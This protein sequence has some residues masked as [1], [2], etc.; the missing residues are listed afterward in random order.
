[1]LQAPTIISPITDWSPGQNQTY[2][3]SDLIQQIKGTIPV[4]SGLG[5]TKI[6]TVGYR[7]KITRNGVDTSWTSY[8][9][10]GIVAGDTDPDATEVSWSFNTDGY[11][12]LAEGDK[13]TLNFKSLEYV[14]RVSEIGSQTDESSPV[15]LIV[16]VISI[17]D[18]NASV[19]IPTG[20]E[21]EKSR[22]WI[23]LLVPSSSFSLNSNSTFLGCNFY[24][25]LDAGGGSNGYQLINDSYINDPDTSETTTEQVSQSVVESESEGVTITTTRS[26]DETTEYYTYTITKTVLKSLITQG[27][28]DNVFLSDNQTLDEDAV[29]YFVMTA[30]GYDSTLNQVVE[31]YYSLELKGEFVRYSTDFTGLPARRRSDV[32][33]SIAKRATEN[34]NQVNIVSGQVIR[35][36]MDAVSDEFARQYV[37]QDFSF[38]SESIDSLL[39]YDDADQDGES[40]DPLTSINKK[41]L[42]DAL[43]ISDPVIVQTLIDNQFDKQ[44]ANFNLSRRAAQRATG[45][46]LF[47]TSVEPTADILIP[48]GTQVTTSGDPDLNIN[49][50][51]FRVIGQ[52]ILEADNASSYYNATRKRYEISATIEAVSTG[53]S[54]NV[55]ANTITSAT[56]LDPNL[57]V[58]NPVPT[59]H[60]D[61]EES[62]SRLGARIKLARA[63]FDSGTKPGYLSTAYGVANVLEAKVVEAGNSLMVRDYDQSENRHIGGK[64]DIYIK[65]STLS[66]VTDQVAFKFEYPTDV[67][68]DKTGERFYV[69]DAQEFRIKTNNPRV[70]TDTPI[71]VVNSVRNSTR[72]LNYDLT[73]IQLLGDTVILSDSSQTNVSVGMAAFDV[74]EVDYR[75]RSSNII[76][77]ENQPVLSITSVV[78]SNNTTISGNEYQLI[79]RED[80]LANGRSTISKDGIEFLFD[81]INDVDEFITIT[82]EEHVIR[83]RTPAQLVYKGVDESSIVVKSTDD[84]TVV[85]TKDVDYTVD[86]GNQTTFTSIEIK[87]NGAIRSGDEISVSYQASANFFV[88]Y[89]YD[90]LMSTVQDEVDTMKHS[91]ADVIVKDA[92]ENFIDFS[93]NVERDLNVS[94]GTSSSETNDES[95]LKARI[96]TAIFNRI[97]RLKMGDSITQGEIVSVVL[98]VNGVKT[99]STPFS[100]MMKRN[101]SYIP[102]DNIGK[103]G[104][105]I[106]QRTA[107]GGITSY[108]TLESVLTYPTSENG[109]SNLNFRGVYEDM[110]ALTLVDEP[111]EVA[112]GAGRAYIQA[113]GKII[114][115]TKDGR[116]PQGKEYQAAYY[117]SYP[118]GTMVSQDITTASVEYINV[119]AASF[120]GIDFIN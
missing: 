26:T 25:S 16:N 29:F 102:L 2:S 88:T 44:A 77:L 116:P 7:Y 97:S 24:I 72:G 22:D 120:R 66:Q 89:T 6:L 41:K 15:T 50:V 68:G 80:P 113:D 103:V 40:D 20:V 55:S 84:L 106:Y 36:T 92:V 109:G 5:S 82:N 91:C 118:A 11:I 12:S 90:S 14:N 9:L 101:G 56:D 30:V 111:T 108:R 39:L 107:G 96:Q 21:I 87:Q 43:N 65:G 10:A 67:L 53:K 112:D 37:V 71:V 31:S 105:E 83:L 86:L 85:Y 115:S 35:D 79:R 28:I 49:P 93:F 48:D 98:G 69:I 119:D 94:Q 42:A 58:I 57:S 17:N 47:Y 114:V 52:R 95:K 54:G 110:Q 78:D 1:M 74:I 38:R 33:Y 60:G 51:N 3:T 46:V 63:S 8:S 59:I 62:N 75:Y 13:L 61:D 76:E 64:V 19:T 99:V 81:S 4:P 73:D 104:F 23:K 34:S 18:I 117:V 100:M 32:L 70:S 27:K 45:S